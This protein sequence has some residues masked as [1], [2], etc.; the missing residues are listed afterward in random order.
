VH[1]QTRALSVPVGKQ[2]AK[3]KNYDHIGIERVVPASRNPDCSTR[4]NNIQTIHEIE[5]FQAQ[6][7]RLSTGKVYARVPLVQ[8]NWGL[9]PVEYFEDGVRKR[10]IFH[11]LRAVP[12]PGLNLM[13]LI[14]RKF[15]E[16]R[17]DGR[18]KE[19][20]MVGEVCHLL[21]QIV[22]YEADVNYGMLGVW[23]ESLPNPWSVTDPMNSTSVQR[24]LSPF[25]VLRRLLHHI[26]GGFCGMRRVQ[27][28]G[29]IDQST[30]VVDGFPDLRTPQAAQLSYDQFDERQELYLS[31][32]LN[33]NA[34]FEADVHIFERENDKVFDY[35][36]LLRKGSRSYNLLPTKLN[37][38]F[39]LHNYMKFSKDNVYK[40]AERL[41]MPKL[42][43]ALVDLFVFFENNDMFRSMDSINFIKAHVGEQLATEVVTETRIAMKYRVTD[44]QSLEDFPKAGQHK[45]ARDGYKR[46]AAKFVQD[47][48]TLDVV[49]FYNSYL[50]L[51]YTATMNGLL[52]DS[53]MSDRVYKAAIVLDQLVGDLCPCVRTRE[54]LAWADSIMPDDNRQGS[55]QLMHDENAWA[56]ARLNS[57]LCFLNATV[58]A[59]PLNLCIIWGMLKSDVLTFL[60]LHNQTWR[61][62]M[63]CMQVAPL[64]GHLRTQTEDGHAARGECIFTAKPN[65]VGLNEVIVK[66]VNFCLEGM[67]SSVVSLTDE[68][69][70]VLKLDKVDRR[71]RASMEASQ[72]YKFVFLIAHEC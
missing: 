7:A 57:A 58:K 12:Q 61:W 30:L 28:A 59:N 4:T 11:V 46:N 13:E 55:Q 23:D 53:W 31:G 54:A 70:K 64:F 44:V 10:K 16:R 20:A 49:N 67:L 50:R 48:V 8:L 45:A 51:Q 72:V 43:I 15:F 26:P 14:K 38:V 27:P 21:Q 62:M 6:C 56:Y 40:D 22:N 41:A 66:T 2:T 69:R 34:K 33:F 24:L 35:P 29:G 37:M 42:G 65:S 52:M 9:I 39:Q 60:G 3:S 63:Y 5:T 47:T 18:L 36:F 25:T 17:N 1:E 68:D 71:T 19:A 32:L